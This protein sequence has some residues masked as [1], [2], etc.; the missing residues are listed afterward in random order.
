MPRRARRGVS[1]RG[2]AALGRSVE[3]LIRGCRLRQGSGSAEQLGAASSCLPPAHHSCQ[4]G[5]RPG[6]GAGP[7]MPQ[8][9]SSLPQGGDH[10]PRGPGAGSAVPPWAGTSSNSSGPSPDSVSRPDLPLWSSKSSKSSHSWKLLGSF[11]KAFPW[12][13]LVVFPVAKTP[14]SQ[15]RKPGFNPWSWN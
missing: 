8:P 2:A 6:A 4:S 15:C 14:L 5:S 13:S 11:L 3:C 10:S 7:L 12:T 1:S 9:A